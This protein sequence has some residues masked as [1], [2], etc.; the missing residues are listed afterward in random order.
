MAPEPSA[1][2]RASATDRKFGTVVSGVIGGLAGSFL[3]FVPFA[4]VLGGGLAGY[5]DGGT[6]RAGLTAGAIAGFVMFIPVTLVLFGVLFLLGFAGAPA[7]V[8]VLGLLIVFVAALYTVGF[9]AL[10]G[11]LGAYVNEEW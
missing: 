1:T 11:Y 7:A 5:L 6:P 2:E 9:G 10:G 8:G 3:S 4:T